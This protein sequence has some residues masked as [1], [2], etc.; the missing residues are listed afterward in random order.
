MLS[1]LRSG[2]GLLCSWK[3]KCLRSRTSPRSTCGWRTSVRAAGPNIMHS[4][5]LHRKCIRKNSVAL[6]RLSWSKL[7]FSSPKHSPSLIKCRCPFFKISIPKLQSKRFYFICDHPANPVGRYSTD[8]CRAGR[9]TGGVSRKAK[10]WIEAPVKHERF[11]Q[12]MLKFRARRIFT[13]MVVFFSA[14]KV[15][16]SSP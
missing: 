7:V 15:F 12:I 4:R 1:P 9:L 8:A 10:P 3:R 16:F 14:L 11:S 5:W 6:P 13:K 2:S